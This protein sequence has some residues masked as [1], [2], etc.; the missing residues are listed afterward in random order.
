MLVSGASWMRMS[1]YGSWGCSDLSDRGVFMSW[2]DVIALVGLLRWP[3]FACVVVVMFCGPLRSLITS[4]KSGDVTAK[5][6]ALGQKAEFSRL[7]VVEAQVEQAEVDVSESSNRDVLVSD[8]AQVSDGASLQASGAGSSTGVGDL[9]VGSA[10]VSGS[11]TSVSP[12]PVYASLRIPRLL[13]SSELKATAAIQ[14]LLAVYIAAL[15][16]EVFVKDIVVL[17]G[18]TPFSPALREASSRNIDFLLSVGL[19][20]TETASV[21]R[22]LGDVATAISELSEDPSLSQVADRVTVLAERAIDTYIRL[23]GLLTERTRRFLDARS[24]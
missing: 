21:L 9:V 13:G 5:V 10:T 3:V 20:N 4:F 7:G 14:P 22:T 15:E 18:G 1:R 17:A 6:E 24:S 12:P 11:G 8:H 19:L 2:S 16:V 23:V